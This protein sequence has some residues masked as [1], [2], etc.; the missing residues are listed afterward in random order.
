MVGGVQLCLAFFSGE[1]RSPPFFVSIHLFPCSI[2]F[3]CVWKCLLGK[4]EIAW[5]AEAFLCFSSPPSLSLVLCNR[6]AYPVQR[7]LTMHISV[8]TFPC[9]FSCLP[10]FS[11]HFFRHTLQQIT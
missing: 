2:L 11:A 6:P 8:H 4:T 3:L 7:G 1:S 9:A 10:F 5:N